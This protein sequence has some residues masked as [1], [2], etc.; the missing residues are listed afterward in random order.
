MDG[1]EWVSVAFVREWPVASSLAPGGG[2]LVSIKGVSGL[3]NY[4]F[5]FPA[6]LGTPAKKWVVTGVATGGC[7]RGLR[8]GVA[9]EKIARRSRDRYSVVYTWLEY[10]ADRGQNRVDSVAVWFFS[11]LSISFLGCDGGLG[12]GL[13]QGVVTERESHKIDYISASLAR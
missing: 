13:G 5:A 7:D 1:M 4:R 10:A 9:T 11:M 12:Q 6:P 2:G 8:Q 3:F